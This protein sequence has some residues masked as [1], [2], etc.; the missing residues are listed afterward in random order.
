MSISQSRYIDINSVA[1][2]ASA[3]PVRQLG[4]N[5]FTVNPL[6]PP[7]TYLMFSSATQVGDYFG[8]SSEEYYRASTNYF[9]WV[10][11]NGLRPTALL[12]S[13]WVQ[14]AVA[15]MI[16]GYGADTLLADWVAVTNG[17][18]G[19]TI[20]AYTSQISGLNFSTAT[21]LGAPIN[22]QIC[23]AADSSETLTVVNSALTPVGSVVVGTGIPTGTT[24]LT[25]V[26]PTSVTLSEETTAAI[27]SETLEFIPKSVVAILQQAIN[28]ISAGG[29]DWTA[30]TVAYSNNNFQLTGGVVGPE[31]IAVQAG[32][33]GTDIS[34]SV[35]NT[36]FGQLGWFVQGTSAIPGAIWSQGSA[37]ETIPQ[38]L[39]NC[40]NV[41]NNF[42]SIAFQY[43]GIN[44][45]AGLTLS[46]YQAAAL[47]MNA[48]IPNVQ[49][50]LDVPVTVANATAWAAPYNGGAGGLGLLAGVNLALTNYIAPVSVL[51]QYPEQCDAAIEAATDYTGTNSVQNYEFQ[52]FPTLSALVTSDS[53][54]DAYD[55]L[56]INY[57]GQTQNAGV[58]TSFY[59]QGFLQGPPNAPLDSGVYANE[60]WLKTAF[61]SAIMNLLISLNNLPPNSQGIAYLY[62]VM[63]SVINQALVNGT[64]I[65]NKQLTADQIADITAITNNPLAYQQ[66]QNAGYYLVIIIQPEPG[67]TPVKYQ[68]VY[69]YIYASNSGIRKVIGTDYIS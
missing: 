30:A 26:S 18:L 28:A 27:T 52:L 16:F 66:V 43:T 58:L 23:T 59:Q 15:G 68:A 69:T 10:S 41:T 1:L 31:A 9:N 37:I 4:L 32:T 2:A 24:V 50:K 33:T 3:V 51:S 13:R 63:L 64:T 44:S 60:Q 67:I 17:S 11:K 61:S 55:A 56:S 21:S 49:F 14:T 29:A 38:T 8:F 25:I 47:A 5:L 19:L 34:G 36:G 53:Q 22:S 62:G 35:I 45:N 54:A 48:L 20:G 39:A 65:V 46:Q 6:L 7:Q 42:G 57:I 12:F 40:V